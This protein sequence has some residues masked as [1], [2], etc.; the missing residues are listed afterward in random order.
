MSIIYEPKGR[1]RE[2][3]ELA[4]NVYSGCDHRC[5]YCY[6][7][8][9]GSHGT[10]KTRRD[11]F[12][13]LKDEIGVPG[14]LRGKT[15]HLCFTCDPYQTFDARIGDTR[16]VIQMIH[17]AGGNVAI[18]TKG[19]SRALRDL[20]L[21]IPGRDY[22]AATMT[23]LDASHS[24]YWEPGAALPDDRIDTL[25]AFH[26]AGITTW[27]SLEPVLDPA[28]SIE[29]I[30]RTI[31]FVDIYK[32]GKLNHHPAADDIDWRK[33]GIDAC[34]WMTRLGFSRAFNP[35]TL[36]RGQYYIKRDLA[37]YLP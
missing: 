16:R 4:C 33:F 37:K 2:Y 36:Q 21:M 26:A 8:R 5:K 15:V 6:A 14:V 9:L 10:P 30:K 1:A 17:Y 12:D 24:L 27:V 7:K 31:G 34:T 3:A 25:Q 28:Q 29:I 22:H 11:L 19:G 32:I 13:K 23:Y 35:D 20:D 18:L